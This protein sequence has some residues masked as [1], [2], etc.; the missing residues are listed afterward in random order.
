MAAA[1]ARAAWQ[2]A[3]NRCFVQEDARR[4]PKLS[5]STS[6]SSSKSQSESE[7]G[8]GSNGPYHNKPGCMLN[9]PN[10]DI[11]HDIKWWLHLQPGFGH[12]KDFAY[13]QLNTLEAEVDVLSAGFTNQTS[14]CTGVDQHIEENAPQ[15]GVRRNTDSCVDHPLKACATCLK[16]DWDTR[17]PELKAVFNDNPKSVHKNTDMGESWC[18]DDHL[19][20]FDSLNSIVSKQPKKLSSDLGSHWIEAEKSEP[21]WRITD[22]EELAYLVAQKSLEHIENCDLPQPQTKHFGRRPSSGLEFDRSGILASS[23]DQKAGMGFSS[24]TSCTCESP[25][26]V[27][28]SEKQCAV[29]DLG[30]SL[31][32]SGGL[33]S[34]NNIYG[35]PD[36]VEAQHTAESDPSKAQLLDALSHSQ[37]RA[38]KAEEAAR[39][40][41]TEKEHI[42]KLIFKQASQLFAY[43]QW[44]Y[45]LQLENLCH[46]HKIEEQPTSTLFPDSLPSVPCKGRQS[47]KSRHKS[48]N[49]KPGMPV[50]NVCKSAV[51][52]AV[53]LSLAGAGLLL[54]WTMGWLFPAP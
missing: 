2:R 48:A 29:G 17:M 28:M 44:F 51:A 53:G 21:W 42:V 37:T 13:E 10:S 14:R 39:Q 22:K 9:N 31:H 50:Y 34:S 20:D 3:A 7:P 46:Q 5:C 43:K 4:A 41:Q 19:M 1:E 33:L 16:I 11:P 45:M 54:G 49:Q 40:L 30:S 35:T 36:L 25:T 12:Q 47:R 24:L 38:R 32:V 18:S 8:D 52:F 27:S 15:T 23:F 26:S 6:S